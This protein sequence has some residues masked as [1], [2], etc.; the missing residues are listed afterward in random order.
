MHQSLKKKNDLITNRRQNDVKDESG[1]ISS[2]V[3]AGKPPSQKSHL[4]KFCLF[5]DTLI[6]YLLI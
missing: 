6:I 1:E 5:L 4:F 2:K 3:V